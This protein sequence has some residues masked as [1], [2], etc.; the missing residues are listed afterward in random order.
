L[1]GQCVSWSILASL[2]VP[3]SPPIRAYLSPN[4]AMR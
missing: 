1:P 3:C 2:R 4:V